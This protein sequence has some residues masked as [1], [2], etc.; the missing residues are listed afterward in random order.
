MNPL[1]FLAGLIIVC[2]FF[3]PCYARAFWWAAI[4]LRSLLGF[5]CA[6][7]LREATPALFGLAVARIYWIFWPEHLIHW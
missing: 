3:W 7:L 6:L 4:R 2:W 5:C 1:L